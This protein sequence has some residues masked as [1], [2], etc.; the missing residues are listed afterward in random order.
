MRPFIRS[1]VIL[2]VIGVLTAMVASK[3]LRKRTSRSANACVEVNLPAIAAAKK[4]WAT[5]RTAP[6]GATPTPQ[7]LI[8]FL[9]DERWPQCPAG[10]QYVIGPI[11]KPPAC[12]YQPA[13]AWDPN[14]VP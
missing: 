7:D 9:E 1:I 5:A 6:P 2:A 12:S 14:R 13:H 4:R 10:G 11:G 3:Y 8:P